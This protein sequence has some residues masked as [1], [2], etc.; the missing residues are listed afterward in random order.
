VGV[1]R[2]VRQVYAVQRIGQ[3]CVF[4]FVGRKPA[5]A[6]P[7]ADFVAHLPVADLEGQNALRRDGIAA[8]FMRHDGG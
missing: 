3:G 1:K 6:I 7:L 2:P 4:E 8:L 5:A